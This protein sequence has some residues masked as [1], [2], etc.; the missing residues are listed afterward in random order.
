MSISS[1]HQI[2][3][4]CGF[5]FFFSANIESDR[6]LGSFPPPLPSLS[7]LRPQLLYFPLLTSRKA[8]TAQL[9]PSFSFPLPVGPAL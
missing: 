7:R 3:V 6:P 5:F 9:W 8:G 4:D 2:P 1:L